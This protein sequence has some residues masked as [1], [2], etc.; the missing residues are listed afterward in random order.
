MRVQGNWVYYSITYLLGR[1]GEIKHSQASI[2]KARQLLS[3]KPDA[4]VEEGLR[5]TIKWFYANMPS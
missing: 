3:Y 1:K 4:E 5:E 2:E